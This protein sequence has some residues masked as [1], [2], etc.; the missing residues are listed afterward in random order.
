M[1]GICYRV[2]RTCGEGDQRVRRLSQII[3]YQHWLGVIALVAIASVA[4][5]GGKGSSTNQQLS[6]ATIMPTT[7][8]DAAIG[9]AIDRGVDLAIQQNATLGQGYHLTATHIDATS[10]DLAALT[11]KAVADPQIMGIVGPLD[12]QTVIQTLPITAPAH[13]AM[14]SPGATLPGLTQSAEATKESVDFA[15][16]HPDAKQTTFFRIPTDDNAIGKVAADVA[17]ASPDA[18]GLGA[19]SCFVVNDGSA[20]GAALTAAFVAE[21]QAK[22]GTITGTQTLT[23]SSTDSAQAIVTAIIEANPDLIFYGG[24]LDGAAKIRATLSLSGAQV[25]PLMTAG[26]TANAP[27]WADAVGNVAAAKNTFT[28]TPARELSQTPQAQTFFTQYQAAYPGQVIL[29]QS[30]MAYDAAMAEITAI[31]ALLAAKKPVTRAAITTA[32]AATPYVGI[33]G[34][35]T[36]DAT[37]TNTTASGYSRYSWSAQGWHFDALITP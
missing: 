13:I 9:Q 20:S 32:L 12:S 23:M 8:I 36:F 30:A 27:D 35:L 28:L 4:T 34:T 29:A 16:L 21:F 22:A 3:T 5:C 24:A 25:K 11:T 15:K 14:I 37:G 18:N 33:T 31:K 1:R 10:P 17:N 6:I 7:G 19:Q 26:I 2:A